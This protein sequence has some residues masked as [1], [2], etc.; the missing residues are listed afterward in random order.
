MEIKSIAE[1]SPWRSK[2]LQNTPRGAFCNTFD[3]QGEHSGILLTSIKL[4][5]SIKDIYYCPIEII[6][7][8]TDKEQFQ[9]LAKL[10]GPQEGTYLYTTQFLSLR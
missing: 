1:C 4:P 7:G 5:F 8:L 6:K 3:L 10:K 2:I 9:Y